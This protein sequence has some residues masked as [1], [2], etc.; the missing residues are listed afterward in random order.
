MKTIKEIKACRQA[1]RERR[2]E[3][4]APMTQEKVRLGRKFSK[5]ED[6]RQIKDPGRV[7]RECIFL[8]AKINLLTWV[9]NDSEEEAKKK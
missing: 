8:D 7:R 5:K 3:Y 9:I 2:E 6:W 1:M 4:L